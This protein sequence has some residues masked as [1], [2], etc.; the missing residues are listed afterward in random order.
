[1]AEHMMRELRMTSAVPGPK[2][3]VHTVCCCEI[4]PASC[5][6]DNFVQGGFIFI[7]RTKDTFKL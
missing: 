4:P 6:V 1:M 7:K 5:S 3:S 2:Q